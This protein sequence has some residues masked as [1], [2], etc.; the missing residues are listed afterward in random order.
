MFTPVATLAVLT[1]K[2]QKSNLQ[3]TMLPSPIVGCGG[4]TEIGL[5][6]GMTGQLFGVLM[7]LSGTMCGTPAAKPP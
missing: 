4:R 7:M 3:C 1:C 5:L 6:A 2:S